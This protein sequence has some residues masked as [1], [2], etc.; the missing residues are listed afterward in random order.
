M[1]ARKVGLDYEVVPTGEVIAE[2]LRMVDIKLEFRSR[3]MRR[4]KLDHETAAASTRE[5]VLLPISVY[6][7]TGTSAET[8]AYAPDPG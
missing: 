8:S 7:Q 5:L 3:R 6:G 2:S 1:S 4:L